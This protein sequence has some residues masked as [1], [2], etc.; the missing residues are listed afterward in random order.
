MRLLIMEGATACLFVY[1]YLTTSLILEL[2]MGLVLISLLM[3]IAVYDINHMVIPNE[4]V[5][6]TL[7][8]AS[9][10]LLAQMGFRI[11]VNLLVQ[12]LFSGV[13]AAS[14]YAALWFVSKGRWIGFGDAKLAFPLGLML[15]PFEAF[16][17]VVLS[18][19]IGAAISVVLLLL[20]KLLYSG[21]KHLRFLPIPLTMKSEVPFAPFLIAAF[22]LVFF[23]E[24]QVTALM[25]YFFQ[26]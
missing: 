18:F 20:Q 8:L 17:M 13:L 1:V 15:L 26:T 12:H 24:I 22:I 9:V 3:V 10:I 14:F 4:F 6:A 19:W 11:E 2:A 7:V 23:Q 21:K 16:S 25:S 5:L